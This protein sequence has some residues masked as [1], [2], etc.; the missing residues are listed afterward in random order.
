MYQQIFNFTFNLTKILYENNEETY[1]YMNMQY[2][3]VSAN[4]GNALC[5]CKCNVMLLYQ[6]IPNFTCTDIIIYK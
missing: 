6:E 2:I 3:G 5:L 1:K 4:I